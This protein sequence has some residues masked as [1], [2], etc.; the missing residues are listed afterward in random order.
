MSNYQQ[1]LHQIPIPLDW[2][3]IV[4]LMGIIQGILMVLVIAI[5]SK[6]ENQSI[7]ILGLLI[8]FLSLIFLDVFLC[9]TGYMKYVIQFN[10]TTEPLVLALGPLL[11]FFLL[12]TLQR[13]KISIQKYWIHY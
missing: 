1:S 11:Y 7:R 13:K 12:S 3:A 10:D 5:R 2:N 8:L 9:Y 6:T 4:M